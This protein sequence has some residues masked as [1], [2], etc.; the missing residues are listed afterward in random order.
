MKRKWIWAVLIFLIPVTVACFYAYSDYRGKTVVN[1]TRDSLAVDIISGMKDFDLSFDQWVVQ[2]AEPQIE[3]INQ[4]KLHGIQM[5]LEAYALCRNDTAPSL[6]VEME[7]VRGVLY[8]CRLLPSAL[9]KQ[10]GEYSELKALFQRLQP[11]YTTLFA[12][13]AGEGS[14][15]KLDQRI[16]ELAQVQEQAGL[17]YSLNMLGLA[18]SE[19]K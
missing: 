16:Q 17:E 3:Q 18:L 2:A 11:Y 15:E 9:A 7:M 1:Q 12:W 5:L 13:E 14:A 4:A 8:T 10:H 19:L 6:K